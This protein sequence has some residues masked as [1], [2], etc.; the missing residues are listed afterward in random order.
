[1]ITDDLDA[2]DAP[3]AQ[4]SRAWNPVMHSP[5]KPLLRG[6]WLGHAVHPIATDVVIG[7][8]TSALLLDLLGGD[9]DAA[10]TLI[11]AGLAA[12][13]VTAWTGWSDWHD[14]EAKSAA[15]RRTGLVHAATVVAGIGL[16]IASL[17]ARRDGARGRGIAL[18]AAAM[19]LTGAAG[20]L[21]GHMTYVKGSRVETV[22]PAGPDL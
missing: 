2:L 16:Q 7:S 11:A 22:V 6:D 20:W 1:M 9:E 5:V 21:G 13:P 17:A 12:A 18:S 3:A 10:A 8:F 14:E 15:I 4:I 19:G